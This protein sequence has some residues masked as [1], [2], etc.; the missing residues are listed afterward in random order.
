MS[1]QNFTIDVVIC[2]YNRPKKLNQLVLQLLSCL[3][4]QSKIIIVESSDNEKKY[5]NPNSNIIIKYSKYKNQPYQRY[6][7]YESSKAD[8]ILYLDDDMEVA[9][10]NVF[11]EIIS[12][13]H[14][15]SSIAGI[16]IK[17]QDKQEETSLSTV[18]VST[19]LNNQSGIKKIINWITCYPELPKGKFGLCGNRGK[20]PQNGGFTE[21]VSGGAF[22]A[23]RELLFQNFNFQLF[24]LFEEKLGMGED[25]IIGYGLHKQGH[26][27]YH[28][29]LLFYH[30]DQ[31]DSHYAVNQYMFAKR[32]IYSRLFLTLEKRRLDNKSLFYGKIYFH[33]YVFCRI[34]GLYLN[35]IKNKTD[36]RKD[37]LKGSLVG[38]KLAQKFQFNKN[39]HQDFD[40]RINSKK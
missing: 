9:T 18:P 36:S 8:F 10:E 31:K 33:W 3:P 35:Y 34:V 6:I 19:L 20:Q 2:T 7:G 15:N 29:T 23:K 27:I 13:I 37:V 16:A 30:N 39:V 28:P 40:W 22:L 24:N 12:V 5:L 17:F 1:K 32:V 38:W 4:Q 14:N 26:L 21:W 11:E 25:A